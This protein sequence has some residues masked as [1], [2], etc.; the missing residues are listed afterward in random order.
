MM[1]NYNMDNKNLNKALLKGVGITAVI[2]LVVFGIIYLLTTFAGSTSIPV[3]IIVGF[4]VIVLGGTL[5]WWY[6]HAQKQS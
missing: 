6:R 3:F 4:I 1:A 2:L 5:Y